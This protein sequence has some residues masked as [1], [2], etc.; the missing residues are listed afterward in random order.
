MF[1]I[2]TGL[3]ILAL[4]CCLLTLRNL[5][6]DTFSVSILFIMSLLS[7]LVG[8]FSKIMNFVLFNSVLIYFDQ[9]Q[10]FILLSS[11]STVSKSC[12]KLSPQQSNFVSS[13]NRIVFR[14][15]DTSYMLFMNNNGPNTEPWGT[16]L[17][18]FCNCDLKLC[19]FTYWY[20]L[21]R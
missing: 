4:I 9:N 5:I 2:A 12:S 20:L 11:F 14:V 18:T 3:D 7:E 13:M 16:P 1:I 17:V 19:I 10:I 8:K 21:C 15:F 6:S